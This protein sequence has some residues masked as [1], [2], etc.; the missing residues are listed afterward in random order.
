MPHVIV[1]L[2]DGFPHVCVGAADHVAVFQ[3]NGNP[4]CLENT[5]RAALKPVSGEICWRR[6]EGKHLRP[7][8]LSVLQDEGLTL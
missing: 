6:C 2:F 4:V 3:S 7:D 8:L 5:G 1:V